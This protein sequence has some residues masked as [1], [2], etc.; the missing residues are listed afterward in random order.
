M[1]LSENPVTSTGGYYIDGSGERHHTG[2]EL[3]E[4]YPETVTGEFTEDKQRAEQLT[5]PQSKHVRNRLTG[6]L[7]RSC[8]AKRHSPADT[9]KSLHQIR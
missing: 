7:T 9:A 1:L 2:D 6:Q 3:L 4:R 5:N 8:R